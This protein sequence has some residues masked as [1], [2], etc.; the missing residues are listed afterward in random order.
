MSWPEFKTIASVYKQ[1]S[2]AKTS[3]GI[4]FLFSISNDLAAILLILKEWTELSK[5]DAG[6]ARNNC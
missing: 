1:R 4:L 5:Q 2:R 3:A 6:A